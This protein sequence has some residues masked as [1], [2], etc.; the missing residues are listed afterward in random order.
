MKIGIITYWW[1]NDNYGQQLQCYALQKYLRDA[2]HDAYLIRYNKDIDN[3]YTPTPIRKKILKAFNPVRLYSYLLNKKRALATTGESKKN[4]KRKFDEFRNKYIKQ[5]EKIYYYYDELK[6]NP[7]EAEMY[8]AGSDQ[9]WNPDIFRAIE[10]Q[11]RAYFLDFGNPSTKRIS[12]AASFCKEKLDDEFINIIT[13]LLKKFDYVSVREESGLNAC[14]QC[15]ID[16]AEWVPD[17]TMLLAADAYRT[18]YKDEPLK[19]QD[20]PYCFLYF[21]KHECDFSFQALYDWAKKNNLEVVYVSANL[22]LDKYEKIYATIPEWI[23]LLEHAEYVITNSYHCSVFSLMFK[24]NFG[25]IPLSKEKEL[26]TRFDALFEL[27]RIEKR[28]VNN[29]DFSISETDIDWSSVLNVFQD[30]RKNCKLL[31]FVNSK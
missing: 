19:R 16:N 30:I 9:I 21:V 3:E 18:I 8:I 14:K 10:R 17:P 4:Y 26:N 25:V 1:S 6:E 20:K 15:G 7:P 28:F 22:Q 24:K 29:S 31:D 27:F 12:Y 23:Y 5:S 13:P 11:A 2:G